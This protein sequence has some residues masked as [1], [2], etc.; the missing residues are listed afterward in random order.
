[1]AKVHSV[2]FKLPNVVIRGISNHLPEQRSANSLLIALHGWLDNANSFLPLLPYLQD[3]CVIALDWV[4]HGHSSHRPA[5][6]DYHQLDYIDDL[7]QLFEQ[8]GWSDAVLLGH[9][10][11]GILSTLYAAVFPEHVNHVICLDAFGPLTGDEK[12]TVS[13]IRA[14]IA[15]RRKISAMRKTPTSHTTFAEAVAKRAE[16][17]SL[18]QSL[19]ET[20]LSRSVTTQEGTALRDDSLII[21]RWDKRLR[22]QSLLR[23]TE[24]QAQAIVESIEC[25]VTAIVASNGFVMKRNL[26]EQRRDWFKVLNIEVIEGYHHVHMQAPQQVATHINSHRIK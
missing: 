19:T 23:L 18:S 25:P 9:S 8:Q 4:G 5:G 14:G 24:A 15:S 16:I 17:S 12:E 20:L 1:M 7:H 26:I 3:Y 22:Q 21:W 13:G 11:G 6:T 2:E 10:M